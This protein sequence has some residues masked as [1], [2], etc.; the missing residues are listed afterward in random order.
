ML[1]DRLRRADSKEALM[2]QGA[3]RLAHF[4]GDDEAAALAA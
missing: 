4:G 1:W 3:R 2:A